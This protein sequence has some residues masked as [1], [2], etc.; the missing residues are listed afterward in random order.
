MPS[1]CTTLH[2]RLTSRII[3]FSPDDQ[4]SRW[5][6]V[7]MKF[8]L[9][10]HI[11]IVLLDWPLPPLPL[12]PRSPSRA[13]RLRRRFPVELARHASGGK[14]AHA[15]IPGGARLTPSTGG[16]Q[17]ELRHWIF[18]GGGPAPRKVTPGSGSSSAASQCR[19][20]C[21]TPASHASP[22]RRRGCCAGRSEAELASATK[23]L[24]GNT[25]CL[26]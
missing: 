23:L 2:G 12:A 8:I 7:S 20:W 13:C 21:L 19:I 1:S 25:K 3:C 15:A 5:Q 4:L 9:L 10:C 22:S 26:V 11:K 16:C 17:V 24:S 18:L 6:D 14:E